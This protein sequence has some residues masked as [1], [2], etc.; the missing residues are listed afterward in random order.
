MTGLYLKELCSIN[1]VSGDEANVRNFIEEKIRPYADDVYTDNM[2]N[3]IAFKKG[4]INKTVML[5]AHMDEVGFIVSKITDSGYLK[6]KTVGGIDPRVVV[7]KRVSIGKNNV[8]GIIAQKAIHLQ[9]ADERGN[10]AQISSLFIDIG[11][12]SK[13]EA[14]E[15]VSLGDY[16]SFSTSYAEIGDKVKAK[17]LDDRVGC[18]VLM[19]IIKE[20]NKYDTYYVFG[21]QEEVGLR[22]AA[23]YAYN[24]KPDIALVLEGTTCSDV[25]GAKEHEYVTKCGGG[26]AV[27]FMDR[28]SI[29]NSKYHKWLYNTAKENGINVQ[30]KRTTMGGNDAGIIHRTASGILTASLSVPCRYIHS[31]VSVASLSDI[32]AVYELTKIF[33]ERWEEIL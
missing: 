18:A 14:E 33:I 21:V 20:K 2:G 27:S 13:E 28:S 8:C 30:Y 29:V 11:A 1:G 6:F 12:S 24:L 15:K 23:V 32:N 17:A 5:S 3:L 31:P 22:G 16:V 25:Y 4:E 10:V 9:K 26:A 19:E 7:S